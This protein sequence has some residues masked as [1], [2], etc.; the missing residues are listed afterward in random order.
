MN[1]KI[2]FQQSVAI[3][4][5]AHNQT[6]RDYLDSL[7]SSTGKYGFDAN[8]EMFLNIYRD[9]VF[10]LDE[11]GY[12]FSDDPELLA[13]QRGIKDLSQLPSTVPQPTGLESIEISEEL[14]HPI[15]ATELLPSEQTKTEIPSDDSDSEIV[16][17]FFFVISYIQTEDIEHQKS[18]TRRRIIF[19]YLRRLFETRKS[20]TVTRKRIERINTFCEPDDEI[21]TV[22]NEKV[23]EYLHVRIVVF[24]P[25][26]ILE[27][28]ES[29]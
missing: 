25:V 26:I 15:A 6:Y 21:K 7:C 22:F 23:N 10:K 5:I 4:V 19:P 20:A 16:Y 17:L 9:T 13:I 11:R 2:Y 27:F 29:S 12:L 1:F 24:I 28:P 18:L 8:Q 14:L 3:D